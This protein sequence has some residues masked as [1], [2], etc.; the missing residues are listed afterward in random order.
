[1]TTKRQRLVLDDSG[2]KRSFSDDC[3]SLPVCVVDE[4][5]ECHQGVE[6][7][8]CSSL[9]DVADP[10]LSPRIERSR[11]YDS[12]VFDFRD[13]SADD[14][15]N[16]LTLIDLNLFKAISRE[17]LACGGWDS[18]DRKTLTPNVYEFSRRFNNVS[19]WTVR[20][21]LNSESIK[22]R[23]SVVKHFVKIAKK[24]YELNSL[25]SMMA[26]VTA[27]Q[28]APIH[29]LIQTWRQL[30][31]KE[32][33][34]FDKLD[35]LASVADNRQAL[36]QHV[37]DSLL[38]CIP[39][40]GLF[41]Q[42]LTYL[43]AMEKQ[44]IGSQENIGGAFAEKIKVILDKIEYFQQSD[45]PM[46]EHLP[47]IEKYLLS[48]RYIQE[49]QSFVD[50]DHFKLSLER[51]PSRH[52]QLPG[53][54]TLPRCLE[55][56]SF[57]Q[58]RLSLPRPASAA[59]GLTSARLVRTRLDLSS[60]SSDPVDSP[61]NKTFK[62]GHRK[63]RSLGGVTAMLRYPLE[64]NMVEP[65]SCLCPVDDNV[66]LETPI[67]SGDDL[68]SDSSCDQTWST[69]SLPSYA[70]DSGDELMDDSFVSAC[71]QIDYE[72]YL[73]RKVIRKMG[74]KPSTGTKWLGL[75]KF[76]ATISDGCFLL[77][78]PKRRVKRKSR[79]EFKCVEHCCVRLHDAIVALN[80]SKRSKP[81][82]TLTDKYS[83]VYKFRTQSEEEAKQ[84]VQ[85]V[86]MAINSFKMPK[87][88]INFDEDV[89]N[90]HASSVT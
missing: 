78:S 79:D 57:H 64:D 76:W 60:L 74:R 4:P 67:T 33:R 71:S 73:K 53:S 55:E 23:V 47:H 27:L 88:L 40:L 11:S 28:S 19:F 35:R 42:D 7:H 29:R 51:E 24:L 38:P 87:N 15:A 36:R 52:L 72:G 66:P 22:V 89:S 10:F 41:T 3:A 70:T 63:S 37:E 86:Q 12:V 46:I 32:K 30:P 85:H 82:F 77:Y 25:H 8:R 34:I 39:Y 81:S 9:G 69:T 48:V 83:S 59:D 65:M 21:V 18:R 17:E 43:S 16:Q 6:S 50:E 14:F 80:T 13:V 54:S 61:T 75:M 31:N 2:K 56:Q 45:Y 68:S 5:D 62:P 1:M 90:G 44:A 84:W 26:M 49:F 20:E 58:Q